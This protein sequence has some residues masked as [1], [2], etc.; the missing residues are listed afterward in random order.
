M[1]QL[2]PK[3]KAKNLQKDLDR[4]IILQPNALQWKDTDLRQ[5]STPD[6]LELPPICLS[7]QL[8]QQ[9]QGHIAPG[10]DAWVRAPA[11]HSPEVD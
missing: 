7:S 10:V 11:C 8:A 4:I 1:L 2:Q 9:G 3:S 5:S 6:D